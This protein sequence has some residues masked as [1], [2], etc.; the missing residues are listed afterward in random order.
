MVDIL[1]KIEYTIFGRQNAEIGFWLFTGLPR[2]AK[3][4]GIFVPLK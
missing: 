4:T 3:R 2:G 1:C